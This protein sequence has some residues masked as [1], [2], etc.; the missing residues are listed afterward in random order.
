VKHRSRTG[1]PTN[2]TTTTQ[3][4]RV[5]QLVLQAGDDLPDAL[6]FRLQGLVE[7]ARAIAVLAMRWPFHRELLPAERL[8]LS[9]IDLEAAKFSKSVRKDLSGLL[10]LTCVGYFGVRLLSDEVLHWRFLRRHK[11]NRGHPHREL[12]LV[13]ARRGRARKWRAAVH[14]SGRLVSANRDAISK[15]AAYF[16]A[17]EDVREVEIADVLR[18]IDLFDP[19]GDRFRVVLREKSTLSTRRMTK[20]VRHAT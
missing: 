4:R 11:V 9:E 1:Q 20:A 13:F 7:A 14:V 2:A 12:S 18:G 17:T 16:A 3:S 8:P 19:S 5:F 6:A 15:L 10:V